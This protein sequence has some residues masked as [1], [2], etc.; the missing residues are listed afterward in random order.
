MTKLNIPSEIAFHLVLVASLLLLCLFVGL[1]PAFALNH[2]NTAYLG[3]VLVR[4][5]IKILRRTRRTDFFRALTLLLTR[6]LI[7]V[8][9]SNISS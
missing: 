3:G 5:I 7:L 8:E 4:L 2:L 6:L 9:A 1:Y